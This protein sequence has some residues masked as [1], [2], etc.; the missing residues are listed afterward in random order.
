MHGR[1]CVFL[2]REILPT[3]NARASFNSHESL[4]LDM[5]CLLDYYFCDKDVIG[6]LKP[7]LFFAMNSIDCQEVLYA[8]D[9]TGVFQPSVLW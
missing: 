1:F 4:M 3:I 2:K 8:V 5:R 7:C 9:P 6:P